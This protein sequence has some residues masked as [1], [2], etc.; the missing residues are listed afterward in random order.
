MTSIRYLKRI[1]KT[2]I[3]SG[4]V[5]TVSA[6]AQTPNNSIVASAKEAGV[7]FSNP[8]EIKY[9]LNAHTEF[10]EQNDVITKLQQ[11]GFKTSHSVSTQ[12][13]SVDGKDKSA[14]LKIGI[15]GVATGRFSEQ[16]VNQLVAEIQV[17]VKPGFEQTWSISQVK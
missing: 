3:A 1:A 17:K 5:L 9:K 8:V 14:S 16:A 4:F 10:P 11:F 2:L 6:N 15:E 13:T 12:K 7:S